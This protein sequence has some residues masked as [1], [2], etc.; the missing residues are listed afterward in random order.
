M[1]IS[2]IARIYSGS[3]V[4]KELINLYNNAKDKDVPEVVAAIEEQMR[5]QFSRAANKLFGKK[6]K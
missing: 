1:H 2:L 5:S 4:E 6:P 3:L